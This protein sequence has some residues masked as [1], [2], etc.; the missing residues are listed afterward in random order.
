MVSW[1]S[2]LTRAS[3][4]GRAV[5]VRVKK[6]PHLVKRVIRDAKNSQL[7]Q[8]EIAI[9]NGLRNNGRVSEILAAAR[10]ERSLCT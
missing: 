10:I 5:P 1:L 8:T 3:P 7:T 4:R 2:M 6:T 9:R